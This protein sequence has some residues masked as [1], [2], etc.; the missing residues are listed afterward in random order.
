MIVL[1]FIE[2][3]R[4]QAFDVIYNKRRNAISLVTFNWY[5]LFIY[6]YSCC[7]LTIFIPVISKIYHKS[8]YELQK[9]IDKVL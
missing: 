1:W 6:F 4:Y 5:L 3:I 9:K 2:S 7:F 8:V